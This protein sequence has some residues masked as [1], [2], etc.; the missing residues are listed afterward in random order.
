MKLPRPLFIDQQENEFIHSPLTK[1]ATAISS[2]I[3]MQAEDSPPTFDY[4]TPEECICV[5]AK[6]SAMYAKTAQQFYAFARTKIQRECGLP[7]L[8]IAKFKGQPLYADI[9]NQRR[10]YAYPDGEVF[11]G[12]PTHESSKR[13][14]IQGG[15]RIEC[16]EKLT[17]L[18]AW[19]KTQRPPKKI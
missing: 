3:I 2:N 19:R 4:G 9:G 16:D 8:P 11:C 18:Q 12:D 7:E 17:Q 5:Q 15:E 6:E 1:F 13:G 14:P 10:C